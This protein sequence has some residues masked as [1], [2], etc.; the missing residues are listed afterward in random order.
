MKTGKTKINQYTLSRFFDFHFSC[1]RLPSSEILLL[2]KEKNT[3]L[4]TLLGLYSIAMM[5]E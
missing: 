3:S 1:H 4:D 5:A 2:S